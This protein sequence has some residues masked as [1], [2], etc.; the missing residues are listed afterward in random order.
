MPILVGVSEAVTVGVSVC[1]NVLVRVN[2]GV[3]EGVGVAE[4]A[5]VEVAGPSG[6]KVGVIVGV[7]VSL[8]V[9]VGGGRL[10]RRI[11]S[12]PVV[13]LP[14]LATITSVTPSMSMSVD[15]SETGRL[16]TGK[17]IWRMGN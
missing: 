17:G 2:E 5:I 15:A 1:V 16:A 4:G 8:G 7:G 10:L 12:A 3:A 6:V 11:D 14:S 13:P 9:G